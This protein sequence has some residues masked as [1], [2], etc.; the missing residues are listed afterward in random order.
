MLY[1]TSNE[2]TFTTKSFL[3]VFAETYPLYGE[4]GSKQLLEEDYEYFSQPLVGLTSF[5]NIPNQ[6]RLSK[7][8]SFV[9][10]FKNLIHLD[11]EDEKNKKL[12]WTTILLA[13]PRVVFYLVVTLLVLPSSTA[14]LITELL[15]GL[16][17]E[18][19][20]LGKKM[21]LQTLLSNLHI[22]WDILYLVVCMPSGN[23]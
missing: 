14:K 18:A 7:E 11:I 3:T 2:K 17:E 16:G 6:R 15:P 9:D 10:V 8:L 13:F 22:R 23:S 21:L 1:N 20:Y 5:L 4:S 12:P 19:C